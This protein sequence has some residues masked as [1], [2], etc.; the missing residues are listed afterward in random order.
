MG[1]QHA[2]VHQVLDRA[3]HGGPGD[4]EPVG[5][6]DLVLQPRP[7]R[8]LT[9]LDELLQPG[10]HL[11]VQRHRAGPVDHHGRQRTGGA[12]LGG[13]LSYLQYVLTLPHAGLTHRPESI[14]LGD[15]EACLSRI[16]VPV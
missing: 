9:L 13:H 15:T 11:E 2:P 8:Q 5:E 4:T 12:V 16:P 6:L 10:G 3:A 1:H 14:T 7:H